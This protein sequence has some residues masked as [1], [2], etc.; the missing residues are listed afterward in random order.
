MIYLHTFSRHHHRYELAEDADVDPD[1][2]LGEAVVAPPY[3]DA[4]GSENDWLTTLARAV[5]R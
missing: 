3:I 4:I 5:Y 1:T 2:N